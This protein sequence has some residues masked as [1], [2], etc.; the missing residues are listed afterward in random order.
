MKKFPQKI[1]KCSAFTLVELLIVISI[2]LALISMLQPSLKSV[3]KNSRQMTCINTERT[4]GQ[5]NN[6]YVDDYS[7]TFIPA[8]LREKDSNGNLIY[9]YW[10]ENKALLDYTQVKIYN[11]NNGRFWENKWM[12]PESYAANNTPLHEGYPLIQESYA[13]NKTKIGL[14]PSAVPTGF[15]WRNDPNDPS[16]EDAL[17]KESQVANPSRTIFLGE[18]HSNPAIL[19]SSKTKWLNFLSTGVREAGYMAYPHDLS[20]NALF[21]DGSVKNMYCDEIDAMPKSSFWRPDSK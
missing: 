7:G 1:T 4:F 16:C 20:V 5:A 9:I 15:K 6:L 14:S 18:E 13:L 3:F 2:L 19:L 17:Y 21:F 11:G 12:C 8:W 10:F